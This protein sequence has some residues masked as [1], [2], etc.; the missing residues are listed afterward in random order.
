MR[1]TQDQKPL[2]KEDRKALLAFL[3]RFVS[4][5]RRQKMAAVLRHRTRHITVLLEDI[6]QPQNASA[7][8]RTCDALGLQDV[9]I[10]ENWNAYRFNPDVSLGAEKW[11]TIHRF[12]H[13]GCTEGGL[14]AMRTP[15]S[16]FPATEEAMQ[17][18][19]AKGY[20]LV[21]TSPHTDSCSLED[22]P[23]TRKVAFLFGNER[24]GLSAY[25]LAHAD[26]HLRLPMYG[27]VESYNISVSAAITLFSVTERLRRSDAPWRLSEDEQEEI[28]LMWLRC[29]APSGEAL[30]RLFWRRYHEAKTQA[31]SSPC[32]EE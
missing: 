26:M 19:R 15:P 30:E 13:P 21:A 10:A 22:I 18:L 17:H 14:E 5:A 7:V 9:Y 1:K 29:S 6:Y 32:E 28:L 25:A 23:L 20:L 27:F 16:S 11:L 4:E 3:S 12:R 8:L 2:S 31:L 24:E